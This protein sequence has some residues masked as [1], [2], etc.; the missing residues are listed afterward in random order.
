MAFGWSH[1]L[2][3]RAGR[4]APAADSMCMKLHSQFHHTM[5]RVKDPKATVD[6]YTKHF[7][8]KL[9]HKY[10]FPQWQFSLYFLET[11]NPVSKGKLPST[12]GT[13]ESEKYV[14]TMPDNYLELT[15]S[16]DDPADWKA[17]NGNEEP[18][19]GFGHIAFHID[20]QDLEASC[21]QLQKDGVHFRKL[22]S[23]GKMRNV[24]FATDPDGYWIEILARTKGG[25]ALHGTSLSQTMLRVVDA[26]K[27]LKFYVDQ[28]GMQIVRC[29]DHGDF[30]LYFLATLTPEQKA[31][32]PPP[33]SEEA[34]DFVS[35][36]WQPVIELTH[37]QDPPAGGR[38][39]SLRPTVII[40]FSRYHNGNTAPKGFGHTAFLVDDLDEFCGDL[41]SQGVP[42]HKKPNEGGMRNI[43]FVLDPD[44][45]WVELIQRGLSFKGVAAGLE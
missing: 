41:N 20:S 31:R 28:L 11:P 26:E 9:I 22:P 37:N 39:V 7:G 15:Y 23:Q 25:A 40:P 38:Q 12:V 30:S 3:S 34:K 43:A 5:L 27:S 24:A 45:Y 19:R 42:F 36:L 21:E 44:G 1:V 10:D 16:W 17:N 35:S 29:S 14:W 18:Y 8:M 6:F 4:L 13:L 2:E 33:Q 32:A